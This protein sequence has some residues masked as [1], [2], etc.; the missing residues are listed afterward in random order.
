MSEKVH[1][2]QDYVKENYVNKIS[3]EESIGDIESALDHILELDNA[4]LGGDAL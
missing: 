4:L 3:F 2:T 1:A